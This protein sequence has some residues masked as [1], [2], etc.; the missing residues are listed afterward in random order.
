[1][2][3]RILT[4]L[5]FI[6]ASRVFADSGVLM[7]PNLDAELNGWHVATDSKKLIKFK[8]MFDYGER[9]KKVLSVARGSS[10]E[11]SEVTIESVS[12]FEHG[13]PIHYFVKVGY[14]GA[15]SAKFKV[16]VLDP[17]DQVVRS[18]SY[19][20]NDNEI[21]HDLYPESP[22]PAPREGKFKLRIKSKNS[23]D[24][25]SCFIYYAQMGT[26]LPG[27]AIGTDETEH[28]PDE[29]KWFSN[30]P[31]NGWWYKIRA[32]HS[33]QFLTS[34]PITKDHRHIR[35]MHH[36]NH[37]HY[38]TFKLDDAGDHAHYIETQRERCVFDLHNGESCSDV[39][40]YEKTYAE[41]Q[42]WYLKE[43]G[44]GYYYIES[45]K[46]GE[47][48]DVSCESHDPLKP[49][50]CYPKNHKDNQKFM[51]IHAD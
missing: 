8:E 43:A 23:A 44:G 10:G 13:Y 34:H 31:Q 14:T 37:T 6:Y 17:F 2:L 49:L 21:Y 4:I 29:L 7:N 32:K 1:M 16:E 9:S 50:L 42:Q 39:I 26:S 12:T 51:L 30:K 15:D 20:F 24:L 19:H 5:I 28:L 27:I 33:G 48:L 35:Q 18:Q 36:P 46:S 40:E 38:L 47:V 41:N 25:G 22:A 3:N 45:K 11:Y